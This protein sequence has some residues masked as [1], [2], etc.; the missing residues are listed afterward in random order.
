M[1]AQ[2]WRRASVCLFRKWGSEAERALPSSPQACVQQASGEGG[3]GREGGWLTTSAR[4]TTDLAKL[5]VRTTDW[6]ICSNWEERE[7]EEG[8]AALGP[9][10]RIAPRL[11]TYQLV[12]VDHDQLHV[13]GLTVHGRVAPA[14]LGGGWALGIS[15]LQARRR[16]QAMGRLGGAALQSGIMLVPPL[17]GV[18]SLPSRGTRAVSLF[19]HNSG[20]CRHRC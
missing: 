15:P 4:F 18:P 3:E 14:D 17:V 1:G 10:P 7:W 19:V 9:P 20:G 12:V 11:G 8:Q 6:R 2:G 13:L 16:G 5:L